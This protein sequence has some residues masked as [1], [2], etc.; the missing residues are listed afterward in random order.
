MPPN[1]WRDSLA[2]TSL[3]RCSLDAVGAS[4]CRGSNHSSYRISAEDEGRYC[5]D[6]HTGPRCEVCTAPDHYFAKTARRCE[7]C[8]TSARFVVLSGVVLGAVALLAVLHRYAMWLTFR[9]LTGRLA[10]AAA[11]ISLQ[12]KFKIMLCANAALSWIF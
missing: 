3:H 2:T 12:A 1:F 6:G 10:V 4:T 11:Q 9:R 7:A 5:S 8:P